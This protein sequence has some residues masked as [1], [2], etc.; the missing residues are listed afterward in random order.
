MVAFTASEVGAAVLKWLEGLGWKVSL[1][2]GIAPHT[3]Y[4]EVVTLAQKAMHKSSGAA[5]RLQR[6]GPWPYAHRTSV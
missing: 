1:G 5:L 4:P 3:D 6:E 2:S